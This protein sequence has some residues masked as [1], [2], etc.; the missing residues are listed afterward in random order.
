MRDN[1]INKDA[2]YISRMIKDCILSYIP[3]KTEPYASYSLD[4]DAFYI[5]TTDDDE[6]WGYV[7]F[8][9]VISIFIEDNTRGPG[10]E[11]TISK[12]DGE[13]FAKKLTD[14]AKRILAVT[15]N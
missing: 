5:S 12:E 11:D 3:E 14:A 6:Y 13:K 1:D 7:S 15:E 4:K 10:P 2:A 8:D 9:S